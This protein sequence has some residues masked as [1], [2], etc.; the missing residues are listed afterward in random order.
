MTIEQ[1]IKLLNLDLS[2]E[3][4]AMIQYIQHAS[5][6]TGPQYVAII[7]EELQHAQEEH[8]H[9]VKLSDKIQY[10]GGIPTVQVQEIKTSL[11]NVEMLRQDLEAEY[12]AL[13]RYLQ[14]IEQLEAL[15]LYDVAQVIREIAVVEQEHIIDLEKAL[16]IQKVR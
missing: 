2:W 8:E 1:I 4:A 16:G 5:M 11:N 6:L 13:N 9:A 12:D 10:L 3:Y 14:R 7:D 15:K